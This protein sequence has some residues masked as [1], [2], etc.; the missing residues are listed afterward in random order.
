MSLFADIH[1]P[2]LQLVGVTKSHTKILGDVPVLYNVSV[3]FPAR[4]MTTV[5][6]PSGA[7]KTTLLH[8]AAGV[9][10]PNSGHVFLGGTDLGECDDRELARL[11]SRHI[12]L[13]F[14]QPDLAPMLTAY[15]NVAL[16]LRLGGHLFNCST[17]RGAL[18]QVG[19]QD[20]ER[21][22]PTQLSEEQQ[23]RV[24]IARAIVSEPEIVF[25]DEPTGSLGS[26]SGRHIMGLLRDLVTRGRT[27]VVTTRD[28]VTAA[29]ADRVV[30]LDD[31]RITGKLDS[32]TTTEVAAQLKD[33][34][35]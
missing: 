24:A 35:R 26:A 9:A 31:G 22:R 1:M 8:C 6:G 18:R 2:A 13:V 11:R 28:P 16:P 20:G 34:E 17:I 25:V 27:V 4:A 10:R 19:M 23:Q 7:G 30:Y 21:L 15:E 14:Q 29:Y 12:G 32:P 5:V 3:G 33:W